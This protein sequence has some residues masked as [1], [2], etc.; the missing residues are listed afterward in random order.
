MAEKAV[1]RYVDESLTNET[2]EGER[3]LLLIADCHCREKKSQGILARVW[4]SSIL[5]PPHITVI[6]HTFDLALFR[7][8]G[9]QGNSF[10]SPCP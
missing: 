5:S 3:D 1:T 6:C 2:V 9:K 7:L 4:V 10:S 8:F